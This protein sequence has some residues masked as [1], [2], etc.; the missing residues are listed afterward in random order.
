MQ[1]V[2][3]LSIYRRGYDDISDINVLQEIAA[4]V[5][6]D[7][8]NFSS[9]LE[10]PEFDAEVSADIDLARQYRLDG[11]PALVFAEKY[12]VMGAQPYNVLKQVV[13]RVQ[14]ESA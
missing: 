2:V 11:V 14:A 4:S 13:E 1:V 6:L 3:E 7:T 5:G 9:N 12:L 10:N 8:E